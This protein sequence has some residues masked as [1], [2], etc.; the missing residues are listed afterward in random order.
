MVVLPTAVGAPD[1]GPA[2][3][4]RGH[5]PPLRGVRTAAVPRGVGGRRA[6]S[7]VR[8]QSRTGR[9]RRD[10]LGSH[11][12]AEPYL[13]PGCGGAVL[14]GLAAPP[15]RTAAAREGAGGAGLGRGAVC[16]AGALADGALGSL[17][18]A[19]HLQRPRHP[20]RPTPHRRPPRPGPGPAA[21]R[22]SPP[23]VAASLGRPLLPA[24]ARAAGADLLADPDHRGERVEPRLVHGRLPR[25]RAADGLRGG[26]AGAVPPL[27]ANSPAVAVGSGLDRTQP[28][29]RDVS[30][31]LPRHPAAARPRCAGWRPAPDRP[32]GDTRRRPRLVRPRRTASATTRPAAGATPGPPPRCSA[33]GSRWRRTGCPWPPYRRRSAQ[34]PGPER[35]LR[36]TPSPPGSRAV[37]RGP[38]G[39]AG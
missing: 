14:S 7:G 17:G 33:P 12:A 37:R 38:P 21:R 36:S 19:P 5:R 6:G 1:A 11:R 24:R 13:V 32:H 9:G 39:S 8:R 18:G 30:V 3:D 15:V 31:A 29:L 27:V 25:R 34:S 22:R 2:G 16:A 10:V 35:E 4:V 20:R 28:Q 23:G 26:H